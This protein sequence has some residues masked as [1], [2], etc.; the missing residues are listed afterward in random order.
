MQ[1]LLRDVQT[2][3][4]V[5]SKG[6]SALYENPQFESRRIIDLKPQTPLRIIEVLN[7]WASV[8]D[9]KTRGWIPLHHIN[10]A[11]E[12][13]GVFIPVIDTFLRSK[14]AQGSSTFSKALKG[15]RW[16]AV[17]VLDDWLEVQWKGQKAFIDLAHVAHRADMARWAYHK[18]LGWIKIKDRISGSIY[19]DTNKR[20]PL[21]EFTAF[22]TDPKRAIMLASLNAGPKVR[23]RVTLE[24]VSAIR[25]MMSR[26]KD[27]GEVWWKRDVIGALARTQNISESIEHSQLMKR[28]IYSLS[29]FHDQ[30][31]SPVVARSKAPT[32]GLVSSR[33]VYRTINGQTWEKIPDFGDKNLPVCIH[34]DGIW[35]VG[36]SRSFDQGQSFE[37][38][39]RWDLIAQEIQ[40]ELHRPPLYLK[41]LKISSMKA[42]QLEI[43]IDTGYGTLRLQGHTLG[44]YW[45]IV[46]P[47]K[48]IRLAEI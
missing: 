27:H 45:R 38:Y 37:P 48:S 12:D 9:G 13:F 31:P 1:Q 15:S 28:S 40:K 19:S 14:P 17:H 23:S 33:G 18:K 41:L 42:S 11:R 10:T 32:F 29:F 8:Y 25:W 30:K 6:V 47:K 26:L 7:H 39:L 5:R 34:P 46:S 35:F 4:W 16:A 44:Q 2:S 20:F 24:S 21:R 3:S 36:E 43:S 22:D